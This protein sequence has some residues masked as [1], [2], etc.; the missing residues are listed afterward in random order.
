[1]SETFKKRLFNRPTFTQAVG[2]V[3]NHLG[4]M[5]A[6]SRGGRVSKPFAERIMMAVT[7]VNGCRY[8]NYA[9]TRAALRAG[10]PQ[11]EIDQ[12]AVGE[13]EGL[14][15]EELV[16]LLFAQHY[17]ESYGQPDP[18]AW[19]RVVDSY[20][21]DTARDIAVYVRMI[22]LG[23][24]YGNTFDAFLNRFKG[25]PAAGSS[26]WQELGVLVG[27]VVIV[28]LRIIKRLLSRR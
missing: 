18:E 9:H 25:K 23:N 12:L 10:V 27:G 16:A 3:V 1:M 8:C 14:P 5:R 24:L 17:A 22:T 20:G 13:F 11:E 21:P 7:Q 26:V 6:A 28:P 15:Q 19:Q 4:D 2:D